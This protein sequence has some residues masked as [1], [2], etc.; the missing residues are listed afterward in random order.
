MF[1]VL[2]NKQINTLAAIIV[3]MCVQGPGFKGTVH[4][5]LRYPSFKE[6]L[7]DSHL[8]LYLSN[9]KELS[10]FYLELISLILQHKNT[11]NF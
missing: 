1:T 10:Y 11:S 8:F 3:I 9:N 2:L 4:V 7:S 5:H 6:G